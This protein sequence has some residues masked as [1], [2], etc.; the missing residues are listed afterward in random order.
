MAAAL[1]TILTMPP[2]TGPQ[3]QIMRIDEQDVR[4]VDVEGSPRSAKSWGVAFW[5]WKLC[6]KDPGIQ[7]F[8]C[9]YK[10]DDLKTLRDVWAKVSVFFPGYLQP[11]WN[12][13]EEAWDFPN[14]EWIGDVYTGSRVILSSLRVAEAMTADAVH[15]KYKGKTLA[16][17]VVEEAQEVP[18]VNYRG[19]K[20]RLSQGAKP[21]GEK[22]DYPLRIVL[23]HNCVDE[24]HWIAKEEF[25]L[26]SDGETCTRPE[27]LH[28][29][30]D[31]Y[32]NRHNLGPLV[33][34]GYEADYPEGHPLR[35]TV[36][37]GKRGVTLLGDPV[38]RHA[39][40]RPF[41]VAKAP[42]AREPYYP[43][44]EGWD[45]GQQKPAVV[46]AQ[47]LRHLAAIRILGAV[48][49]SEVF[50]EL[51]APKV[52]EIR[53]ALFGRDEDCDIRSWCDPTGAVGNGGLQFTPVSLL[54]DLGVQAQPA[55]A[56]IG[57]ADGNDAEVRDKAIQ[58]VGGYMHKRAVDGSQAFQVS[59]LCIEVE[60]RDGV[61]QQK[62]TSLLVTAFEVGYIWSKSPPSDAH[63]NVRKPQ[64]G[65]R[66]DDLMN[67]F[68]YIVTGEQIPVAPSVQMLTAATAQYQSAPE[69]AILQRQITEGR[70]LREQQRDHDPSDRFRHRSNRRGGL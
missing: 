33:M 37:E 38:Y 26:G 27:H 45:F 65:T 10:D 69:R 30:A 13:K 29:R 51:F 21:N 18:I 68:E 44:L 28:I 3:M 24:D 55:R 9:R 31:L 53:R 49:G 2:L 32:S 47:Y 35:R 40:K 23:V 70:Q 6:Y 67:A 66:F 1:A 11:T 22:F 56:S 58:T 59:P 16:V 64:K 48:K 57:S 34:A 50:L 43:L 39:F 15:G 52:L 60:Y 12:A 19:L 41:H 46:W 5:M 20:E 8:Y 25:P 61:W 7:V 42:I 4:C 62:E 54:R 14:G 63:P 17:I 36:I